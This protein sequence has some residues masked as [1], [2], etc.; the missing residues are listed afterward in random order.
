MQTRKNNKPAGFYKMKKIDLTITSQTQKKHS[1]TSMPADCK[2]FINSLNFFLVKSLKKTRNPIIKE[3]FE[4]N[5][6]IKNFLVKNYFLNTRFK[7]TTNFLIDNH[8]ISERNIHV[9]NFNFCSYFVQLDSFEMRLK[10]KGHKT[11]YNRDNKLCKILKNPCVI[12]KFIRD[13]KVNLLDSQ[14]EK[15]QQCLNKLF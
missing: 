12:V 5:L 8:L 10:K 9:N 11:Y 2:Y 1:K 14:R 15:L 4:I 3:A 13:N 6:K 7:K